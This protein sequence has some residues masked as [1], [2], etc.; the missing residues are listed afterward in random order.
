MDQKHL[1]HPKF[2]QNEQF[3]SLYNY[4]QQTAFNS[5]VFYY[6]LD[7]NPKFKIPAVPNIEEENNLSMIANANTAAFAKRISNSFHT[8]N[9]ANCA[10]QIN[11]AILKRLTNYDLTKL[12]QSVDLSGSTYLTDESVLIVANLP[13]LSQI[14]LQYCPKITDRAIAGLLE[15]KP[16]LRSLLLNGCEQLTDNAIFAISRWG[17]ALEVLTLSNPSF[18]PETEHEKDVKRKNKKETHQHEKQQQHYHRSSN[19]ESTTNAVSF[20]D[21]YIALLRR[22]TKLHSISLQNI[23]V[24]DKSITKLSKRLDL[25][26]ISLDGCQLNGTNKALTDV[27]IRAL[28]NYSF[29][30]VVSFKASHMYNVYT[31]FLF[32]RHSNKQQHI[33]RHDTFI[34]HFSQ[35]LN[36]GVWVGV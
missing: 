29:R 23:P 3:V 22:C 34:L 25:R 9:L 20:T 35:Y 2:T 15:Q 28:A 31:H 33:P 21:K 26:A 10:N 1:L 18:K 14:S 30:L 36:L 16:T 5:V 12:V 4:T 13:H 7:H 8:L 17:T 27:T 11:P 24:S 6:P 19:D 32:D